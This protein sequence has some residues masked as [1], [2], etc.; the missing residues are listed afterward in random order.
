MFRMLYFLT[1]PLSSPPAGAGMEDE[2]KSLLRTMNEVLEEISSIPDYRNA[3]KKQ[4]C[5][6]SRRL[7]LLTPMLEEIRESTDAIDAE[8][9]ETLRPLG[10]ALQSSSELLRFGSEGSK[11]CLV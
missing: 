9:M 1:R 11:I 6:L 8:T 10:E 2:E 3:Y 4:F 5:N 7:K